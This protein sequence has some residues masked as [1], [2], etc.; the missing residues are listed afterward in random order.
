MVEEVLGALDSVFQPPNVTEFMEV[1]KT[2]PV[3]LETQT[4][5]ELQTNIQ[6]DSAGS[7]KI[8]RR[9]RICIKCHNICQP[10][11][12][13]CTSCGTKTKVSGF[14]TKLKELNKLVR[15]LLYPN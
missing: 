11:D 4:T 2:E 6:T 7:G 5:S 12:R 15:N 3:F 1:R 10:N 9:V 14:E 13:R 8:K